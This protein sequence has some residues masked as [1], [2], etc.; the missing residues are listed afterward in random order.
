MSDDHD[1]HPPTPP[2]VAWVVSLFRRPRRLAWLGVVVVVMYGAWPLIAAV[3]GVGAATIRLE[4]TDTPYADMAVET[5][6]MFSAVHDGL[7]AEHGW[8]TSRTDR[9]IDPRDPR[10]RIGCP[11]RTMM[12]N[13]HPDFA[14]V[15]MDAQTWNLRRR[16]SLQH[17]AAMVEQELPGAEVTVHERSQDEP[18]F[19]RATVLAEEGDVSVSIHVDVVGVDIVPEADHR[20]SLRATTD[21]TRDWSEAGPTD[22]ETVEDVSLPMEMSE[23]TPSPTH[24]P[25]S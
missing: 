24:L 23:A 11:D 5:T 25:T 9:L 6:R 12:G 3:T 1:E 10:L 18:A 4:K 7:V 19:W 14:R 20:M 22:G 21:C 13:W 17:I 8:P 16:P 2:I 15:D